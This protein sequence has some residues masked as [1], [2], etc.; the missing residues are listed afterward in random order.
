MTLKQELLETVP[1]KNIFGQDKK[2]KFVEQI[3]SDINVGDP[4]NYKAAIPGYDFSINPVNTNFDG[5][6]GTLTSTGG[7]RPN[8]YGLQMSKPPGFLGLA[9]DVIRPETGLQA[10]NTLEE[11]RNVQDLAGR[12]QGGDESAY[13]EFEDYIT[14]NKVPTTGDGGGGNQQQ[15]DPCLGP[16]PPAYCAV[17]NDPADEEDATPT[18]NLGGLA[19]R[20]AGSIFDFTG[21]AD[22]G[23]AGAMDG[24]R[25]MM[26]ANQEEDDPTGGI[27]DLESGRQ[28]YFLGKLVKK[29]T[30][31]VKKIV[32]SPIGKAALMYFGGNALMGAGGGK[33]LSSF[34]GKGS[35]NPLRM[36]EQATSDGP[37]TQD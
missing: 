20:F 27:M 25:M 17:N 14:R 21:L 3:K 34:F 22:G 32:K 26:M 12:F 33:G 35:F 8:D 5:G 2:P 23:R 18:R 4:K 7:V 9:T 37:M 30:R 1:T 28:M 15:T 19:P 16:N 10:F 11:A 13:E 31:A 6:L 24:G 29:A 36:M